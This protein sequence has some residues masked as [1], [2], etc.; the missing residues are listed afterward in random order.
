MKRRRSQSGRSA[1]RRRVNL[2]SLVKSVVRRNIETSSVVEN[3][4]ARAIPDNLRSSGTNDVILND[5]AQGTGEG[6]R[7][8]NE[9]RVTGLYGDLFFTG[10][11]ATNSIR[12]I[13]YIPKDKG[14]TLSNATALPFNGAPDLDQ[15]TIL[16]D[17]LVCTTANGPNCRRMKLKYKFKGRGMRTGFSG[18]AGST[19]IEH[20]LYIYF[21]SD[22]T[23]VADPAMN[24]Y[25][26]TY[27]KDG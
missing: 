4:T 1:K 3:F 7:V 25:I 21:V 16:K 13:L 26:R 18:A 12:V 22:S 15:F 8:K 10:A 5:I 2:K 27:Y 6:E 11:D 24:G 20:P 17:M 19:I 23:A 14:V 9:I